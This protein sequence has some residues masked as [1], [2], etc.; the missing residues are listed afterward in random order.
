MGAEGKV[1]R[2]RKIDWKK[3][4]IWRGNSGKRIWIC[5]LSDVLADGLIFAGEEMEF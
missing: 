2:R 4:E 1:E 5:R 3:K